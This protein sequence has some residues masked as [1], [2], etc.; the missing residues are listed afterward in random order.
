[1]SVP[2]LAVLLFRGIGQARHGAPALLVLAAVLGAIGAAVRLVAPGWEGIALIS[3]LLLVVVLP[4]VA[5][6]RLL[7]CYDGRRWVAAQWWIVALSFLQWL[8]GQRQQLSVIRRI[9]TLESGA[10]PGPARAYSGM[11]QVSL[12]VHQLGFEARWTELAEFID[13]LPAG[14][15][16][17]DPSLLAS[18]LRAACELGRWPEVLDLLPRLEARS[19]IARQHQRALHAGRVAVCAACGEADGVAALCAIATATRHEDAAAYFIGWARWARGEEEPAHLLIERVARSGSPRLR[20]SARWRLEHPPARGLDA[21]QELREQAARIATSAYAVAA[22]G[23]GRARATVALVG[24]N[25]AVYLGMAS[26]GGDPDLELLHLG[27]LWSPAIGP[28]EWWRF[29]ASLFL[30]ANV[31]HLAMNMI[32]LW[33]FGRALERRFAWWRVLIVY[34]GSG[35]AGNVAWWTLAS[36]TGSEGFVVGASGCVMGLVGAMAVTLVRDWR[37]GGSPLGARIIILQIAM[38]WVFDATHP[39]VAGSAHSGGLVVGAILALLLF[40]PR[41]REAGK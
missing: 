32:G 36:A 22:A 37:A 20:A 17:G 30:H 9:I 4:G 26:A 7:E 10:D 40:A 12:V 13:R 16:N 29:G 8:P 34:L 25:I 2:A 14:L 18:R 33:V 21:P 27:A 38:Q 6:V 3:L 5:M 11:A 39:H 24:A 31:L 35:L 1:M 41:A 19:S 15:R 28:A 23:G